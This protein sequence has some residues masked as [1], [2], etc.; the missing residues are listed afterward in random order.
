MTNQAPRHHATTPRGQVNEQPIEK[1]RSRLTAVAARSIVAVLSTGAVAVAWAG[2]ANASIPDSH[3]VFHGCYLPIATNLLPPGLV[4]GGSPLEVIDPLHETCLAGEN[5]VSWSQI[6]PQGPKGDTGPQ[7]P[8]G[9]TGAQGPKGDT[10]PQGQTGPPG[11]IGPQ[12]MVGPLGPVGPVGPGGPAGPAGPAGAADNLGIRCG[13][14]VSDN[15]NISN[16]ATLIDC[17]TDHGNLNTMIAHIELH[18][19][20][21]SPQDATCSV[22]YTN[23]GSGQVITDSV[24]VRLAEQGQ[25]DRQEVVLFGEAANPGSASGQIQAIFACHGFNMTATAAPAIVLQ[26]G[27]N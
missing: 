10:G 11:P 12:G 26:E 23:V 17:G 2:P 25:A 6:G 18:N 8:K 9:D 3:G 15:T 20:D 14:S 1:T 22:T 27:I 24:H 19:L 13:S 7:G 16:G 21:S 5:G 4:P